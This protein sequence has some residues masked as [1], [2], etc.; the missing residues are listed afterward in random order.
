MLVE[1]MGFLAPGIPIAPQINITVL[2]YKRNLECAKGNHVVVQ[3]RV[4]VPGGQKART[5]GM[6]EGEGG[7]KRVV[8]VDDVTEVGHGFMTFVHRGGEESG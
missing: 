2:L 1:P 3:G 6:K 8:M 4:G 7:G 5:M